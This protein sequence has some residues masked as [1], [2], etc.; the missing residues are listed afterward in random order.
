MSDKQTA[1]V[2]LE[3]VLEKVGRNTPIDRKELAV[4]TGYSYASVLE[5]PLPLLSGKIAPD[6]FLAWR[7]SRVLGAVFANGNGAR[8]PKK[9]AGKSDALLSTHD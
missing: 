9:G 3:S 5:W 4:W 2:S 6:D 1:H 8:L 7:M